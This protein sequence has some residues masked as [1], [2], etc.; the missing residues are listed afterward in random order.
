MTEVEL[1]SKNLM[2][3]ALWDTSSLLQAHKLMAVMMNNRYVL[4]F[5]NDL[6]D[7]YCKI[8]L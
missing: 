4:I 2:T 6:I 3:G 5:G 1:T 7:F 8:F